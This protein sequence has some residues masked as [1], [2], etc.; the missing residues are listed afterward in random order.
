MKET[1]TRVSVAG[2]CQ[3]ERGVSGRGVSRRGVSG[4]GVSGRGVPVGGM[5]HREG[6]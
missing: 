4:R 5:L 2:M 3:L 6:Q 1:W